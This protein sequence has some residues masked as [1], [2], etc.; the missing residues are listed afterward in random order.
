MMG[1]TQLSLGI[2]R[3]GQTLNATIDYY[4]SGYV[5][6]ETAETFYDTNWS[7]TY[8]RTNTI[9]DGSSGSGYDTGEGFVGFSLALGETTEQAALDFYAVNPFTGVEAI[10]HWNVQNAALATSAKVL[11]GTADA[12]ILISGSGADRLSGAM[13][14]DVLDGGAGNDVLRG[15][16]GGDILRGGEGDDWLDGGAGGD[17]LDGGGG[18]N[19]VSYAG[20]AG[21]VVV[22]LAK[23]SVRGGDAAGDMLVGIG[24]IRGSAKNDVL[25]GNADDNLLIGGGGKDKL[26]GGAGDDVL[27]GD[28]GADVLIG[29]AGQDT[30]SY[31]GARAAVFASLA[32]GR[33]FSGDARDDTFAEIENLLGG[34]GKD[35]LV[36]D[37]KANRLGG[38]AGDDSLD[39]RGGNDVLTGGAGRDTFVFDAGL[40]GRVH[41][42]DF[43]PGSGDHIQLG[44]PGFAAFA[45][46][47][48]AASQHGANVLIHLAP[49]YDIVLAGVQISALTAGDFLFGV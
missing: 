28:S 47:S 35:R 36:G 6:P 33:G 25:I 5:D 16:A 4:I 3:D 46:V 2:D 39:G 12:D 41:I 22:N 8:T 31:A 14:D 24:D 37:A 27:R 9:T 7:M 26:S 45:D 17:L 15:G 23:Q 1:T 11:A 42:R 21:G 10:A 13:G 18:R 48:A 32:E 40:T 43:A 29:G 38:G 44:V 19:G 30:A 20:S 34:A 49:G